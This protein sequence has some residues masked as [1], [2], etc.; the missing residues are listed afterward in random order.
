M[1]PTWAANVRSGKSDAEEDRNRV[2]EVEQ[3]IREDNQRKENE[4]NDLE[5]KPRLVEEEAEIQ[6]QR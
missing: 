5:E 4:R 1:K 2:K 3:K 6:R